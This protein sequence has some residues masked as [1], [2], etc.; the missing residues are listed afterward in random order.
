[1]FVQKILKIYNVRF[2]NLESECEIMTDNILRYYSLADLHFGKEDNDRLYK[3]LQH[4]FLTRLKSDIEANQ[5]PQIIFFDGDLYHRIIKFNEVTARLVIDFM[6]TVI[7]LANENDIQVRII[8]GTKSHDFNQLNML[9]K[10]EALYPTFKI[11]DTV[12]VEEIPLLNKPDLDPFKVLFLPEE[13]PKDSQA[14][15]KEYLDVPENTYDSIQGHGTLDFVNLH[16]SS[17]KNIDSDFE[18]NIKTAPVF[19]TNKLLKIAKG[20]V[21]FGHIHNYNVYKN[22]AWY[23]TSYTTYSF[24]DSNEKGYLYTE[25]N[26][27]DRTDIK[28]QHIN[29]E[30]APTYAIINMDELSFDSVEDKVA[31]IN[32]AKEEFSF[33]RID[34]E[35]KS[36]IDVI[37]KI[38]ETDSSIKV[39]LTDKKFTESKI[40]DRYR[41][42]ID[43]K[44]TNSIAEDIQKFIEISTD[45]VVNLGLIGEIINEK[46]LDIDKSIELLEE[47]DTKN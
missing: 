26:G 2:I 8:R 25:V 43:P 21:Q 28:V 12:T 31:Y 35:N 44:S 47:K 20:A 9:R 5:P 33:V 40:D 36:N 17:A 13:Y 15:Y 29:N 34:S 3:E 32:Q 27:E 23:T 6:E 42:L 4:G 30:E 11:Y 39:K 22:R 14:Y 41:F 1:M 10:Y 24:S 7:K 46:P 45:S 37:K 18:A 38:T 19:D 16:Q